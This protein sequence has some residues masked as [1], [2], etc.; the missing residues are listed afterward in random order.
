[1]LSHDSSPYTGE[2]RFALNSK[3]NQG[4]AHGVS[5]PLI[6]HFMELKKSDQIKPIFFISE[7]RQVSNLTPYQCSLSPWVFS[8]HSTV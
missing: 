3:N 8:M 1:M 7:P 4:M 2:P 5:H 6:Y